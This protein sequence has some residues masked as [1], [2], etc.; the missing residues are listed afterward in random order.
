MS[1][2]GID[3]AWTHPALPS[4]CTFVARYLSNDASKNITRGEADSL[5]AQGQDI[6]V[7][8]ETTEHEVDGG[9]AAG[10]SAA[11]K[12]EAQAAAAGGPAGGVIYF[13]VD[14]DAQVGPIIS[15][16]FQGVIEVLGS[17]ARVGG[18]GG[19]YVLK[20][21][22][23][24]GLITYMWQAAAWSRD[25]N[26]NIIWDPRNHIEQY[27]GN[28]VFDWNRTNVADFGQWG[29]G[30][31]GLPPVDFTPGA[32]IVRLGDSGP[33]VATLQAALGIA[34]DGSFGPVTDAAVR[35]F[36]ASVGLDADGIVG[37]QTWKAVVIGA[38]GIKF[39]QQGGAAGWIGRPLMIEGGSPDG[40]GR[41]VH[42]ENASIYWT[43]EL[44]AWTI[45]GGIYAKWEALGYETS[46]LGYPVADE[47]TTAD[48]A[49]RYSRFQ[50]GSIYYS[51]AAGGASASIHGNILNH[52]IELG[53][54]GGILGYPTQ[55]EQGAPDGKGRFQAFD[56]G[57]IYWT[58]DTGAYEVHGSILAAWAIE[59]WETGLLG[60][61]TSDEHDD[62]ADGRV[63]SFQGAD[64]LARDGFVHINRQVIP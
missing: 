24:A 13:A 64:L 51:P 63:S 61:P 1:R 20:A 58:A 46:F 3:Y 44:G 49:G 41:F 59:K 37:A 38:I 26:N 52:W 25:A 4:G 34:A 15:G 50:Y 47:A 55:D 54:E 28:Q 2:L 33:D 8:W 23:D 5:R 27:A 10:V 14:Y 16:Y 17:V 39:R 12:S 40:K 45:H 53:A 48:G 42:F 21:L 9:H 29:G 6:A 11:Q 18:Y 56:H 19:Y 31:G 7:V 30:G 36:Q 43:P 60:Y 57:V 62:G 35:A 22:K 32:R